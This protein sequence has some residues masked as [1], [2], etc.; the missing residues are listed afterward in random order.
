MADVARLLTL[1]ARPIPSNVPTV[2]GVKHF[3]VHVHEER[4]T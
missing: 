4:Q 3:I 2:K 1:L